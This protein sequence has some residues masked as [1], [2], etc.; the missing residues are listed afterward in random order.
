MR[1]AIAKLESSRIAS[2]SSAIGLLVGGPGPTARSAWEYFRSASSEGVV[3]SSS[4]TP[5]RIERSD[6]PMPSR[7]L[8]DSRSTAAMSSE[9]WVADSRSA[10]ACVPSAALT[11]R[12]LSTNPP[13]SGRDIARDRGLRSLAY[14]HFLRNRRGERRAGSR[15]I[16]S[17]AAVT[18]PVSTRRT[19]VDRVRS[20]RSASVTVCPSVESLVRFSKSASTSLSRGR[21][22]TGAHQR[23]EG[24]DAAAR[25]AHERARA[26]DEPR[27][28]ECAALQRAAHRREPAQ[29]SGRNDRM[30]TGDARE[31]A[32]P[33]VPAGPEHDRKAG[34]QQD[35]RHREH[36]VWKA[37]PLQP[38][39]RRG[40][41]S[42][43]TR[44]RRAARPCTGWAGGAR[45]RSP[46]APDVAAV[47]MRPAARREIRV[48]VRQQLARALEAIGGALFQAAHHDRVQAPGNR[49]AGHSAP[50][51]VPG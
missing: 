48:E 37:E 46:A 3:T 22:H 14:R 23:R 29:R 25:S 31:R 6:S 5:A 18:S 19:T 17:S 24:P 33:L 38:A 13:P 39:S 35:D 2:S 42:R 21:E 50:E 28:R 15:S 32:L 27:E 43:A 16:R 4:G 8:R 11:T 41:A 12:A 30:L 20:I 47:A 49:R 45:L 1:Q 26:H 40:T 34:D 44:A 36:P 7:T 51:S 9:G 10:R